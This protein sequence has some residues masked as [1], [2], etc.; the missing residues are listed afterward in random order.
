MGVSIEP[1][2]RTCGPI[3]IPSRISSTIDGSLIRGN[4]P[5]ASG[6]ANAA[7]ATTANP[8]NET[9][10]SY[11]SVLARV[12]LNHL[13]FVPSECSQNLTFLLLGHPEVVERPRQLSC[14]F[15]EDV[16]RD[17]QRAMGFLQAEMSL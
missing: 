11:D 4:S 14:D 17:L 1:Q 5:S 16:G 3:T 15:I 9:F 12:A 10:V 13:P 2:P 6:A 7:A 8:V